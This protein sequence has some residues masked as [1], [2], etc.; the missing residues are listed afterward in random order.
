MFGASSGQSN[1]VPEASY[2]PGS[3]VVHVTATGTTLYIG[4]RNNQNS[5][6]GVGT[7]S[8]K[9]FTLQ[10]IRAGDV[11]SYIRVHNGLILIR[12]VTSDHEATGEIIAELDSQANAAA[13]TW[14]MET[15]AWS[16]SLGWPSAVVLYE[17]RLWFGG[18]ARFPQQLWGSAVDDL[19]NFRVGP[20]ATDALSLSLIDSGGNITLNRLRW[21]MPAENMLTGTTHGEYRLIG[22]GDDPLSP[23]SL[24]RNRIQSTFGSDVVQPLKVGAALLFVQRQGSKVRE[25]IFDDR[26]LTSFIARDIT[27]TSDH[28]LRTARLV[29]LAYQPEPLSTVWGV[30][31]DGVALGLTY[32]QSE[33]IIAW[34]QL[35]TEGVIHSLAT[36]PH[37][38]ANA[39]QLWTAVTR[40]LGATTHT[41]IEVAMPEARMVLPTPVETFNGLTET[42]ETVTGW[43]GLTLDCANVYEGINTSVLTG[44]DHFNGTQVSIV[45]D[46]AVFPN[47]TVSGGQV[48]LSQ[49]VHTAW[50]GIGYSAR[51][52]TLPV[53]LPLRGTTGQGLRKRWTRLRARVEQ[54]ACLVLNG[55]RLPF[56]QP[57]MAMDQGVAPFSGDREVQ[58]L[59]W[60]RTGT[61]T[62]D[63]D[64]PLPCTLLGLMGSLEQEVRGG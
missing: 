36:I 34:W 5:S 20:L 62:F 6:I 29:E 16:D 47:Q 3:H 40:T 63:V 37:P 14:S 59:G 22:S 41:Y 61:I 19:F 15:P 39:H 17:G 44:L 31:S 21:L 7:V 1:V 33:Q 4:F 13:G 48:T 18:S 27:I 42:P 26:S 12:G 25:M 11:G 60:D 32:D 24:P 28:L 64:Q 35:H 54:T 9:N 45:A 51:G 52:R 57:H 38:T 30:R 50:V 53:E 46:G 23:T 8:C 10:T 49:V 58:P 43:D 2:G 55:E 56:R